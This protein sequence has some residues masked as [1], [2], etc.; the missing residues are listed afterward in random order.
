MPPWTAAASS[1]H[2]RAV[3]ESP[4]STGSMDVIVPPAAC[5]MATVS[6]LSASLTS[7]PTTEAPSRANASAAAR[8]C[9]PAVPVMSATFP[10]KRPRAATDAIGR[11]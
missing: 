7:Q 2:A 10:C 4:R 3:A 11:S 8:P 5:T 6:R 1:T 9:P